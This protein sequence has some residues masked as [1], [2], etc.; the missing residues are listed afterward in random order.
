MFNPII[1][2][3]L[4]IQSAVAKSSR[5]AGAV[6]GYIITTGILLWGSSL[7]A[8]GY[9][10]ALFGIPLSQPIF[11]IACLVWYGF[12]T[13]EFMAAQNESVAMED[14]LKSPL[15]RVPRVVRFYQTTRD[16][17][18]SGKLSKL[19]KGFE[20]EGNLPMKLAAQHKECPEK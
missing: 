3:A 8:D 17:W 12:D 10:V 5:K 19:N 11:I 7:Y 13:K 6:I 2:I 20:K 9:Q 18:S 1:I 15:V 14:A 16:A 4:I